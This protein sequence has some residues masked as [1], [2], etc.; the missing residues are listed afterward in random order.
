MSGFRCLDLFSE[1]ILYIGV[2]SLFFK[3]IIV[4]IKER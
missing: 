2:I 4:E 3:E 1:I